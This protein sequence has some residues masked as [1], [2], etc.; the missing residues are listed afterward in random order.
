MEKI[1][2]DKMIADYQKLIKLV[3]PDWIRLDNDGDEKTLIF[4]CKI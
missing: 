1:K 2:F 4:E 3:K